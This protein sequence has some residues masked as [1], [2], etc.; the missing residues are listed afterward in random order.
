M[1]L[2]VKIRQN[3]RG[4]YT[5]ACPS[6]PGCMTSGH[7]REEAEQRL[8]EAI[9]GYLAA[10]CNFVPERVHHEVVEA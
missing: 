3:D 5:A 2:C 10:A 1:K 8:D 6:L 7:T 4:Q 9:R